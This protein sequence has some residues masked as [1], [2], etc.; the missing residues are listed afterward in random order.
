MG[1]MVE[2]DEVG[3]LTS[4]RIIQDCDRALDSMWSVFNAK[5]RMVPGLA[6]RNGHCFN[7]NNSF[8]RGG[9]H[10]KKEY[11]PSAKWLE[12]NAREVKAES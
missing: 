10:V 9:V 5:G 1:K 4:T 6:N 12:I 3:S 11:A 8:G 7:R 2:S